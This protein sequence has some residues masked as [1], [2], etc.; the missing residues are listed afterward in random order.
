MLTIRALGGLTIEVEGQRKRLT[1]RV[2]EAL[3]VYLI[4]HPDPI[5]R[6]ML[7]DLLWQNSDP[8]QASHNFRSSLSRVRRVAGDYLTI[9]RQVVGFDHSQPHYFDVAHFEKELGSLM[10]LSEQPHRVDKTIFAQMA[11]AA[12][13]FR[14]D[15]LAGFTVRGSSA[16]FDSWRLLMQERLHTLA[17]GAL[18]QLVRHALYS[19]Q[20]TSGLQYAAQLVRLDPLN[21]MA[22]Q[23]KMQLHLRNRDRSAALKQYATCRQ[24]LADELGVEPLRSTQQLAERL[25]SATPGAHNLPVEPSPLVGRTAVITTTLTA[26][27]APDT[28]LVTLTG[29]GGIGKTRVALA[30]ARELN[31]RLRN[32]IIFIS[33]IGIDHPDGLALAIADALEIGEQLAASKQSPAEIVANHLR[34]HECLLLLDNYEPLLTHPDATQLV[35]LLLQRAPEVQMLITSRE[36]LQLYEERVITLDGLQTDAATLFTQHAARIRGKPLSSDDTVQID[37]ICDLLAGVPLALELAAGH[38]RTQAVAAIAEQIAQT[39]DAL[40]TTLR[41]LPPRQRSLRAAFDYS[42]ELLAEPL[43]AQLA[44]LALFVGDFDSEAAQAVGVTA[45]SL[46][47]LAAKS[48]LQPLPDNRFALHP[49]ICEFVDERLQSPHREEITAVFCHHYAQTFGHWAQAIGRGMV[50]QSLDAWRHDHANLVQAWRLAVAAQDAALLGRL[51]Y[52]LGLFHHWRNWYGLAET[53]FTKAATALADW[54]NARDERATVYGYILLRQAWFVY[55]QGRIAEAIDLMKAARPVIA[56]SGDTA[57]R[58]L[59]QRN[60]VQKVIKAGDYPRAQA[61][62]DQ[63]LADSDP[64]QDPDAH[65]NRLF[66]SFHA[67]AATGEY[68]RAAAMVGDALEIFEELADTRRILLC[69]YALGNIARAQGE[70]DRAIRL[71]RQCLGVRLNLDDRRGVANTQGALADALYAAGELDEAQQL[72]EAACEIYAELN[73]KIG[74]PY[75]LNVLGNIARDRGDRETAVTHYNK[76]LTMAVETDRQMKVA[77]LVVDWLLLLEDEL[78]RDFFL[79]GLVTIAELNSAEYEH[80]HLAQHH[81]ERRTSPPYSPSIP[82]ATLMKIMM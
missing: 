79:G 37:R 47:D 39:L 25:R 24:I 23:L 63:L 13:L 4:A 35:E 60:L 27:L 48:L 20:W 5:P 7:T 40:Q 34:D 38:T 62:I 9:S 32:G 65:A 68:E 15:F 12:E 6:D 74:W 69:Q 70:Y 1:A 22:H 71:F 67:F 52:P 82:L 8:K 59:W 2:D 30:V 18:Q 57:L 66:N 76:A 28:R 73:D 3:L 50:E 33:L 56:Q 11:A 54:R 53:L 45:S 80:R 10:P 61:L 26:L 43:R 14:G 31:G 72:A 75:P 64:T 77:E 42:W 46:R 17:S 19:G 81:L 41:N 58:D 36:S 49:L 16:E 51:H 21:E 44:R 78:E 55:V 29:I